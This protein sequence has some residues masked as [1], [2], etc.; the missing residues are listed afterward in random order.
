MKQEYIRIYENRAKMFAIMMPQIHECTHPN[1]ASHTHTKTF[2]LPTTHC[3]DH[4]VTILV[5]N[6]LGGIHRFTS[7]I[8]A[9]RLEYARDHESARPTHS[10]A[11]HRSYM[12]GVESSSDLKRKTT[13]IRKT[14]RST[15]NAQ[16]FTDLVCGARIVDKS[17]LG[18][19]HSHSRT[20]ESPMHMRNNAGRVQSC[21]KYASRAKSFA[22]MAAGPITQMLS[23]IQQ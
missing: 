10:N 23:Q 11:V 9:D 21:R 14:N 17:Q 12:T 2:P 13:R 22:I 5:Q 6:P 16:N 18:G 1:E 7:K 4:I 20:L 3:G 19:T 15:E 8:Y